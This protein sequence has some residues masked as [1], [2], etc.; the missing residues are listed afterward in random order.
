MVSPQIPEVEH[1]SP[2]S[3]LWIRQLSAP[4]R[5]A[6]IATFGGWMLDGMDVMVYSLV[7]PDAS[8]RVAYQQGTSWAC[9]AHPLCWFLLWAAGW[10]AFL[11]TG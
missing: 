10:Q 3:G 7:L 11:P 4:E 2:A 6:F 5:A 9:S 8:L 1:P